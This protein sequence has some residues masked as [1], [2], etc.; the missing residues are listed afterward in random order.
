MVLLAN[1]FVGIEHADDETIATLV[2]IGELQHK[3]EIDNPEIDPKKIKIVVEL[4]DPKHHDVIKSFGVHNVIIS[5]RLTSKM[6][7][8]FSFESSLYGLFL[9]LLVK[10]REA[11]S[12]SNSILNNNMYTL[13]VKDCFEEIPKDIT[14]YDLVRSM[15]E[16]SIKDGKYVIVIGIIDEEGKIT[17]FDRDQMGIKPS[18]TENSQ[19]ILFHL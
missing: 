11:G 19:M 3:I 18:I 4:L 12:S 13:H 6:I 14:A 7:T 9:E 2:R 8:Q 5:N 10:N 17:L 16:S 15:F 1:N